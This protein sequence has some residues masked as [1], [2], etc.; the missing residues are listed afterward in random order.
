[1]LPKVMPVQMKTN[2]SRNAVRRPSHLRESRAALF[3]SF[4]LLVLI[5]APAC[6][7][8]GSPESSFLKINP[9]PT[10]HDLESF[11]PA[12]FKKAKEYDVAE[13]PDAVGVY[14]GYYTPAGSE[15]I[16]YEIRVY[17][18]HLS[19]IDSGVSYAAE[20]TGPDALLRSADVRWDVGTKDRRGG[21]A[22]RDGLAPR[23][24]A[25]AGG[26]NLSL[27]CDGRDS[28]PAWGLSP[29]VLVGA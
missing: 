26:G 15:P 28:E 25:F 22:F 19:A 7:S 12:G 18:D 5:S 3:V 13:L 2:L 9:D 29:A 14:M 8:G 1:M 23:D 10:I 21:G 11:D 16:Q 4:L 6:G 24:A 20:V 27:R 17:P